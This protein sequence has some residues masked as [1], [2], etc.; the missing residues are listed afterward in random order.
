MK[1]LRLAI[2]AAAS[3]LALGIGTAAAEPVKIAFLTPKTGPLAFIGAMYDPTI[4]FVQQPFNEAAGA[5]GNKI[6]I[7]VYDDSGTT[8]GAADRFKQAIAD[9][10]RVFVGAGTSPLAAQNLADIQRWNQR[11]AD[12]PAMLLIVGAEGS[13]FIGADCSFY[14]FHF[15]TTPFIRQNALAKVMKEDGSLG[16]KVYS[17]QPDY[18]MGREMEAA[19]THN[20]ETYGYKV[21]GTTRHDV[22]K[23]KDFSPF[24]EKARSEAPNTIFTASS[25][26]DLQLILQAASSSGL[27]ARF[28]GMFL[29]EPGNLAAAGEA[30]LHNYDAQIFNAEAGGEAGEKYRAAFNAAAGRDPVAFMNNSVLTLN[31]LGAAVAALPKAD[32]VAVNDLVKSLETVKVDWPLGTLS[33]RADDH[34][35]QLPLVISM[36]SKDAKDKIDGTDMG[37]KPVKVLSAEETSVPVSAECKMKRL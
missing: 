6:D 26:S 4:N 1:S 37:F 11:N 12:D 25:G 33:M 23:I 20:A 32:K 2:S 18:T 24:I 22:F 10:A 19:T 21:A 35:V 9:G 29:D 34:Q 27:K 5:T 7:T 31:M 30:A 16:E 17:L 15:T 3:A 13:N 36:V 8:Q 14:S 28:A